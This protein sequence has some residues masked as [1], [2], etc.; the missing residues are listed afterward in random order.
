MATRDWFQTQDQL[1]M[2][3]DSKESSR[4]GT[5]NRWR[6]RD[7]LHRLGARIHSRKSGNFLQL[8]G[9]FNLSPSLFVL[10]NAFIRGSTVIH[11]SALPSKCNIAR[12]DLVFDGSAANHHR[13]P[14]P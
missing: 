2:V 13:T 4:D 5:W 12:Q 7:R 11:I 9:Y 10:H 1:K 6:R 3:Q 8:F 14:T